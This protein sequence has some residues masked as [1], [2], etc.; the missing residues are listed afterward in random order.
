MP[1]QEEYEDQN[2][3]KIELTAEASPW[4]PLNAEFSRQE[5]SMFDYWGWFV[6]PNTPARVQLFFNSVTL[7]SYDAADVIDNDNYV[8]V[9]ESF[10]G[11][12]LRRVVQVSTKKVSGLDH[13]VLAREWG[14]SPKKI[15]DTICHSTQHGVHTV[16][17]PSLSRRFRTNNC[18]LW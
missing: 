4:D 6:S 18:W 2:I 5:Q 12:L 3:L 15:L 13:L 8:T 17:N 11:T 10:V 9:L 1:T 16:L 7:F 14:I